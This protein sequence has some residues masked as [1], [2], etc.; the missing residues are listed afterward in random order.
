MKHIHLAALIPLILIISASTL[1]IGCEKESVDSIQLIKDITVQEAFSLI[2]ENR[3]NP[4]FII[5]DVRTPA[6]FADGHINGAINID[7]YSL[8]FREEITKL[9]R[10][11]S[12]LIHCRSG[13]RSRGALNVM[14]ELE[15]QEVYHMY[16]GIIGWT[17]SGYPT[18]K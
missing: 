5:I 4:A 6:E 13:N 15:F 2:Q 1:V 7:F 3:E 16:E 12:V 18:V 14:K 8:T 10:A 11:K 17:D 9:D